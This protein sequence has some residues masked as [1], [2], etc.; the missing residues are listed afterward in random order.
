MTIREANMKKIIILLG[1]ILLFISVSAVS[2]EG[3]FT[4]LQDTVNTTADTLEITQDYTYDNSSDEEIEYG[5]L[6]NKS[7]FVLNGN[8]HTINGNNQSRIFAITGENITISNLNLINGYDKR[9]GGAVAAD[10]PIVLI[11]VTITNCL[12]GNNGGA[13][14]TL[15]KCNIT[16]C[17]FNNNSAA[18]GGSIYSMQTINIINSTFSD[19]KAKYAAAIYAENN[20]TVNNSAFKNLYASE[21]A[22]AIGIKEFNHTEI[23]NCT[24][25]NTKSR[26][27]GGA[28]F[29]DSG[30]ESGELTISN[31]TF[32]GSYGDFG[33]ALVMLGGAIAIGNCEFINNTA[34]YD[35]GAIY[36]SY[37]T[38][39]IS[40]TII[41]H[42]KLESDN[43]SHGGGLYIDE[44]EINILDCELVNN[45]M[46]AIYTYD[47]ITEVENTTFNNNGE[48]VHAVFG[49]TKLIN[50]FLENDTYFLND[51][52]YETDIYEIGKTI[53][54]INNTINVETLPSR[55]DSRD[56]GWVS[57]VKNQGN[58]GACWTF[59]TLAALESALLKATGIEYDFSENNM[60]N[61]MLQYSKYGINGSVEGGKR[62]QGLEYLIS[63]FGVLPTEYDTYDELG[64][65]SPLI[66]SNDNIHILD[67]IFVNPRNN[68]TDNDALK[69]A[70]LRCG[71][72]T[73]GY[74][75]NNSAFNENTSAYY[76]N[77]SNKTNHAIAIVGWD[78]NY[79]ASNFLITPPENGAFI[80]KNSWGEDFGEK[81]Y[82]YISY[83]DTSLLN[84]SFA[85]GF[86]FENLENY[87]TVYQTDLGGIKYV[88]KNETAIPIYKNT[89]EAYGSEL[90]SAVGTYFD[91]NE[92]Y[93]L[94]IYVNDDLTLTQ[95]GISPFAG[96]HTVK[97]TE[98]IPVIAGDNFTAVMKK[99][100]ITLLNSSRQHYLKNI[101]W[102]YDNG[103]WTDASEINQT[104]SLKVYTK[105]NPIYTKD[106]VKIYKNA[107]RFEA[108]IGAA[109]ESVIFELNGVNYTRVSDENGT[110]SIAIN[111]NPGE[112]VIK[113]IFGNYSVENTITVLPTLIADNLVKYYRNASQF[114]VSLIDG[115]GKPVT[116]VNITMNINGVFYD[117]VTNE[118]GT[119]RLNINLNPGE[120]IL[121]AI[122][123][124]TGLQMS[125]NI[126]VLPTLKADN[127][128]M[129]YKDGSK[130][131]VTVLDGHGNPLSGATVTFNINGVFYNRTSDADGI[132][133]LNINLM[134]GEYIITS[135]Y[136]DLRISNTITIKD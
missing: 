122:D 81:G 131:N 82:I 117:R 105:N 34:L 118:N 72:V 85:I 95:R 106:L 38:G 22:G 27:N 116:G 24:F 12:S 110:A 127:L 87:T 98:E 92:N 124:L 83:Y 62:E 30:S 54:L 80:I 31:S 128:S 101:S 89:Y 79:P 132:A 3:N 9:G 18:W 41:N 103:K 135:E 15:N 45:T 1:L 108:H 10:C 47:S 136:D 35:G 70:I 39:M 28:I 111:L 126:T 11:N 42:N 77:I 46:Q 23:S 86:I 96:Y 17:T 93:T 107:S 63:W 129:H 100:S 69:R 8:G 66:T 99:P 21:T 94:E 130:F 84:T 25:T 121:T 5:I 90:I 109:N 49:F 61:S 20:L 115:E 112:Y 29:A 7:N 76:Q 4:A 2:A 36:L 43:Y 113:T 75:S 119:A 125:Y 48:A 40:D 37:V 13:I 50:V 68:F 16:D 123:Q 57:S 97:L 73:T 67:A 32:T 133:R 74:Y 44:S 78:D 59:G 58:M 33:G 88:L 55:Y 51:T 104:F 134:A 102:F 56:W 64:K 52:N 14:Y 71:A 19:S 65:L 26:K 91:E 53:V 6:I 114:Y 120:Y 60:Q